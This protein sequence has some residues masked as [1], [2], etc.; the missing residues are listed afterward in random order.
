MTGNRLVPVLYV[1]ILCFFKISPVAAQAPNISYVSPHNYPVNAVI[2]PL[3]PTNTGGAVPAT[4]YGQVSTFAGSGIA[5]STDGNGVAASFNGPRRV[6]VDI[7]D[8]VYVADFVSNLIRKITPGGVATTL[9]I[10]GLSLNGPDGI[11]VDGLGNIYVADAGNNLIKEITAGGIISTLAG[12]GGYGSTDGTGTAASFY[13][14]CGT[15]LDGAGNLY[16]ADYQNQLIRKINTSGGVV[17][18]LAGS[19]LQGSANGTGCLSK[20]QIPE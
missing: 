14:P 9:P 7:S 11:A 15:S 10:S 16:V 5:A 6:S 19:G 13:Y 8:N 4:A 3:A 18:T 17:T 20:F 1:L 12:S 2:T